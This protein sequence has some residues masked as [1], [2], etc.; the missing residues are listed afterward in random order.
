MGSL[1]PDFSGEVALVTGAGG[2]M[3][4]AISLAFAAAGATVVM[5]DLDQ[6]GGAETARLVGERGNGVFVATDVADAEQVAAAVA[7]AVE[8]FGRLDCAVNAAAIENEM[9]PLHQ[10]D[11]EAFDLMQRVNLRGLFLSMK[12]EIIAMLDG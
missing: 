4:R 7:V 5:A 3:G 6:G 1:T 11:D 10:C 8:R 9:V 2:G 12:H